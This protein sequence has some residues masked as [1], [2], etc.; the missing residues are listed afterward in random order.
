MTADLIQRLRNYAEDDR[1]RAHEKRSDPESAEQW[2]KRAEDLEAAARGLSGDIG[3]VPQVETLTELLDREN[4]DEYEGRIDARC[5]AQIDDVREARAELAG[6]VHKLASQ[7][8]MLG[9]LLSFPDNLER[10]GL[11]LERIREAEA[12][13]ARGETISLEQLRAELA[14]RKA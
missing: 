7:D 5:I 6:I 3:S 2:S 10:L 4:W 8:L 9:R 11:D 1:A 14:E 12:Q 13:I